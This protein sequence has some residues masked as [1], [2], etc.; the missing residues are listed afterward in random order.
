MREDYDIE[1]YDLYLLAVADM[2]IFA[3]VLLCVIFTVAGF[4]GCTITGLIIDY[5]VEF[6]PE[7]QLLQEIIEQQERLGQD[8]S[9]LYYQLMTQ[10][11]HENPWILRNIWW[12]GLG[13]GV[14]CAA[15]YLH[16]RMKQLDN[17][18]LEWW[19]EAIL[20]MGGYSFKIQVFVIIKCLA[21]GIWIFL[22]VVC[23]RELFFGEDPWAF[24]LQL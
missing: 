8:T 6:S 17:K 4:L 11:S 10:H 12:F 19:E 7:L 13:S 1:D 24:L 9:E 18:S 15:W 14:W 5:T 3:V 21:I 16:R 23:S 22:N 2:G 20:W